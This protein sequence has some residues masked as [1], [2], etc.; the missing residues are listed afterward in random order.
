MFSIC[1]LLFMIASEAFLAARD[2]PP[3]EEG[4][5]FSCNRTAS[6][7]AIMTVVGNIF[8]LLT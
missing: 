1:T 7:G 8:L 3:F 4:Q 6:A 2:A 5:A